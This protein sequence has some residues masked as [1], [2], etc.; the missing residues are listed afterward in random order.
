MNPA[1]RLTHHVHV[2]N[3]SRDLI[4]FESLEKPIPRRSGYSRISSCDWQFQTQEHEPMD[5][6]ALLGSAALSSPKNAV[7]FGVSIELM[8]T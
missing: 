8:S 2:C 3:A 4:D 1:F 5:I 7:R 6:I